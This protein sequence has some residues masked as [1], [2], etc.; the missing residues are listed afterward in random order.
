LK[1]SRNLLS[2][3]SNTAGNNEA[4]LARTD[5]TGFTLNVNTALTHTYSGS[6][7]GFGVG[8][9]GT[10]PNFVGGN[11]TLT[12]TGEGTQILT[13]VHT[14]TG[15][16]TINGGTLDLGTT[17][18]IASSTALTL[19][20]AGTLDT[21]DQTANYAVPASQ[22]ITFGIDSTGSGSSGKIVADEL[23][24]TNATVTFDIP[25]ALDDAVYVLATYTPG[26]LTGPFLSVPT[27]PAGYTLEYAHEGDKIALVSTGGD[28][29][30]PTLTSITDDVSGGP[31]TQGSPVT[32]TVTFSEDINAATVT[33]ADFDNAGTSTISVGTPNESSPGVFS[34]VVTPT[35]PGTLTLRIPTGAVIEDTSMNALVVPVQD[36]TTITV[37]S[38][39]EA[40][41]G[42]N[43]FG[44]DTNGDGI[45]NGLA[46]LLGAS[47]K[48]V[49]ATGLLPT[50][51]E[52]NSG[53]LV[54]EFDLRATRGSASLILQHSNDVG[55]I[56]IWESATVPDVDS[57]VNDV[58]FDIT[59]GSPLNGV[60]ATIPASKAAGGKLFGRLQGNP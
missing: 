18:S 35:T 26:Q 43:D 23:D 41:S 14:Y 2:A 15:A 54:M 51:T 10:S 3:F 20:P 33:S 9:T 28:V 42:A 5:V 4:L 21:S 31:V 44:A 12:K 1:G 6:I 32:Y 8:T 24:I 37:Q 60:K 17:G 7:G 16:T 52:E 49:N 13:G 25:V 53:D 57:T 56:D 39:F 55:V 27:A 58:V 47:D 48:N 59:A 19:G 29:T 34:V 36:D 50:V 22:P 40:W 11:S 38:Y 30:P 46:W 45:N